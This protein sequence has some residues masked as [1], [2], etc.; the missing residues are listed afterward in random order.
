MALKSGFFSG[1]PKLEAAA[2]S[3]PAHILQGAFGIH[4][5]KIQQALIKLDNAFIASGEVV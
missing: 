4:V 2:I 1:D 5:S 3:D